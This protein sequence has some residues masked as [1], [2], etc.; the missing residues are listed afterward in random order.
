MHADFTAAELAAY[1]ARQLNAFFPAPAPLGAGDLQAG[2]DDA[3]ARVERCFRR[4]AL[5]SYRRGEQA[6]F[7]VFHSDQYCLYLAYLGNALWQGGADPSICGRVFGLNK[8]LH[9]LNCMY[10]NLLPEVVVFVHVLGTVLGKATL[11][12]ELA[13]MQG[14]TIGAIGNVYPTLSPGLVLSAGASIIGPCTIGANVM[15]EPH[16]HVLK[17]DVPAGVRVS[18]PAPHRFVP[19]N[20]AGLRYFFR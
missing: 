10:D 7:D 2:V 9:G 16:V 18:G 11:P 15:L 1:T 3:L 12:N 5:S 14:V 13:V 4:I 19:Q 20:D 17:T 6:R 8:A